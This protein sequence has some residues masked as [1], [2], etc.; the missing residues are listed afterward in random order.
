MRPA[1]GGEAAPLKVL[2]LSTLYP[3]PQHP[4]AGLFVRSRLQHVA[5]AGAEIVVLSPA[6][7]LGYT[8]GRR[9]WGASRGIPER[10][11]DGVVEVLHSRW[12]YPPAS[13]I[14]AAGCLFG[15]TW[16]PVRRLRRRFAFDLIDAHFGHP[17]GIAAACLA[18]VFGRP[19]VVTLRGSEVDHA[20][21]RFRRLGLR[22]ALRRAARVIAVSEKLRNFAIEMG[23]APETAVTIPNGVDTAIFH[24]RDREE[25]RRRLG[26]APGRRVILS[27]GHLI[28]LKGHHHIVRAV[29]KLA[30]RG[31]DA[32]LRIAGGA[33]AAAAYEG[34]IRAAVLGAGLQDRVHFLGQVAPPALAE[35]M[36]AADVFC[37]ASRREGWPNV[38]HEA[39]SCGT[40]VVATAVGAIPQMIP[41]AEYG[42]VV[43]P[44]NVTE[45]DAALEQALGT[46][47][48]RDAIAAWGGARSWEQVAREVLAEMEA[49]RKERRAGQI[50]PDSRYQS[51]PTHSCR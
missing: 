51:K 12:V 46:A 47:W 32:E 42:I 24:G 33:G 50:F 8:T 49:V 15:C 17:E 2:S 48:D 34:E 3:N 31:I 43:P 38:V 26:I 35:W 22:W 29:K 4:G 44:E 6:A 40:P 14:V 25:C 30:E 1:A 10:Q 37:L 7:L 9:F 23:A 36:A 11:Q 28:E 18:A 45:L 5:R 41:R 27:A 19:F 39:L 16:L 20:R 21:H 13:G